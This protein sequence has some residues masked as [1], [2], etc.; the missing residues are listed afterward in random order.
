MIELAECPAVAAVDG[1]G[2]DGD[3]EQLGVGEHPS[4]LRS[5]SEIL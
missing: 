5:L 4:F 2:D 1:G 3:V